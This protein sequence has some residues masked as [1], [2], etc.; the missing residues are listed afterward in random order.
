MCDVLSWDCHSHSS[1]K[2][3]V[4]HS[5]YRL[6]TF[7]THSAENK[8][9]SEVSRYGAKPCKNNAKNNLETIQNQWKLCTTLP[10]ILF[11]PFRFV[12]NQ[13]LFFFFVPFPF[14]FRV[15]SLH[16]GKWELCPRHLKR[17]R[18]PKAGSHAREEKRSSWF[19]GFAFCSL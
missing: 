16:F 6:Q 15:W 7:V 19:F 5:T 12:L 13:V 8:Q 10:S 4:R 17:T 14:F 11:F 9:T 18:A 2:L 3:F 1:G